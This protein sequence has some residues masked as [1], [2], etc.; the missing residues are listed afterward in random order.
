MPTVAVVAGVPEIVGAPFGGACTVIVKAFS[1]A[2]AL[3][4][5]TEITMFV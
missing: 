2:V 4:S 1:A 3:P 5:L